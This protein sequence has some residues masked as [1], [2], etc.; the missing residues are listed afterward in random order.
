MTR[1]APSVN[2]Q[3]RAALSQSRRDQALIEI[4]NKLRPGEPPSVESAT[5]LI[6]SLFFDPKRYDLAHVGRYK[7]NKKLA[8]AQRIAGQIAGGGRRASLYRRGAGRAPAPRFRASRPR[9][10]RTLASTRSSCEVEDGA[11]FRVVGNNFAFIQPVPRGLRCR[12]RLRSTTKAP[13]R[14]SERVHVPT[15]LAL[16]ERVRDGRRCR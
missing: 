15:L 9:P 5:S 3:R 1:D 6:N 13:C 11:E 10:S 16:L 4:Y 14:F 8:L 2:D 7:Y 12:A